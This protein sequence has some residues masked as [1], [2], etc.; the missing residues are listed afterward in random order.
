MI[1][2]LAF[3]AMWLFMMG[4]YYRAVAPGIQQTI[5]ASRDTMSA[6]GPLSTSLF[7]DI[8]SAVMIWIPLIATAGVL[9]MGYLLAVGQRG[10]S[11]KP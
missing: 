4:T 11:F 7:G 2:Y 6:G 8:E 5:D 9:L 3:L 10:T 1:R